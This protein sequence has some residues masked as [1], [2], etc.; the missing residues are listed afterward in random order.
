M[1]T[2]PPPIAALLHNN[3]SSQS[4]CC[5]LQTATTRCSLPQ[6]LARCSPPWASAWCSPPRASARCSP[7][8]VLARCSPPR[9]LLHDSSSSCL[10]STYRVF[11]EKPLSF[12]RFHFFPCLTFSS[13]QAFVLKAVLRYGKKQFAVD[14]TRR[15]T[16]NCPVPSRNESP[17]LTTV[18]DEF[19]QLTTCDDHKQRLQGLEDIVKLMLQQT[20][21]GMNVD[22]A[23]SLLRSKQSPA[24]SAQDPNLV[25]RHS[26]PS[27]HIPNHD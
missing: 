20:S 10:G 21:L 9:T 15:D 23:L 1:A 4:Q 2:H 24:N 18:E 27:T 22:E 6:S 3:C 26:P 13:L 12:S 17:V 25:P 8:R 19:K 14:E 11:F 7:P 16:Y 5:P